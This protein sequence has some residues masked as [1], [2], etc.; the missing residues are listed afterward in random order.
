MHRW[1]P[2]GQ[3]RRD[4]ARAK[5]ARVRRYLASR[6]LDA[7]L[8]SRRNNFAWLT[9]G[10]DNHVVS[11]TAEGPTHLLVT[12]DSVRVIATNI[13]I[14][15]ILAEELDGLEFEP[16]VTAWYENGSH[17]IAAATQSLRVAADTPIAGGP[18]LG[19]DFARLRFALLP[20]EV[21]RYRRLGLAVAAI[22]E[23]VARGVRPGDTEWEIA[24]RVTEAMSARGLTPAVLLVAAD[25]RIARFRHPIPTP[26]RVERQAMLVTV[27]E[28]G[29]LHVAL[30]RLVRHGP[31]TADL[32]QRHAAVVA[33]DSALAAASV[34]G[35]RACD[36]LQAGIAAY[37]ISGYD[38]E[39]RWHHQGGP[40]GYAPREYI[41][42]PQTTEP[43]V[44]HQPVA[45][46]PSV[47]GTKSEDTFLVSP[48]GPSY[49]T[50]TGSWPTRRLAVGGQTIE[51]PVIL[52]L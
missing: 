48:D 11:A 24:G 5:L 19:L 47:A 45:W 44:E 34:P 27:A 26:A 38:D 20:S 33:I 28:A 49:V 43:L 37:R 41:V 22:I 2:E 31:L 51:R 25:A 3:E 13:E 15:R 40:T 29:G 39:W 35:V 6:D 9:A 21:E 1:R 8:L 7:V 18:V 17:A 12:R 46:N 50:M 52:E 10:G 30:S 4:E 16:M 23:D 42:T 14:P 32:A 36:A